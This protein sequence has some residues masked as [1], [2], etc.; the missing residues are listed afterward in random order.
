MRFD[1]CDMSLSTRSRKN[2]GSIEPGWITKLRLAIG[3]VIVAALAIAALLMKDMPP[4]QRLVSA[5][6]AFAAVVT[7]DAR[8]CTASIMA[9]SSCLRPVSEGSAP[10]R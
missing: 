7:R 9:R 5:N 2:A 3:A 10:P 6:Q 1:D 8:D 4:D